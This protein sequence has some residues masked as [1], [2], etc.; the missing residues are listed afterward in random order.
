MLTGTGA[1]AL[2]LAPVSAIQSGVLLILIAA[3]CFAPRFL[4]VPRKRIDNQGREAI[5]R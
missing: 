3:V 2:A 4:R 1:L 5:K